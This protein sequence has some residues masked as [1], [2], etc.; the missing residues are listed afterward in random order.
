MRDYI[1][2]Q[3]VRDIGGD[4]LT[5][6]IYTKDKMY[7]GFL[8]LEFGVDIYHPCLKLYMIDELG[9]VRIVNKEKFVTLEQHRD[10]KIEFI[11]NGNI[12]F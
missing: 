10:N 5:Y 7:S 8:Q 12:K 1:C 2:V 11:I 6:D 9:D 3:S 4:P